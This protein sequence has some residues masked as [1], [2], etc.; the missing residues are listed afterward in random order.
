MAH[1]ILEIVVAIIIAGA[2]F[3]AARYPKV[4]GFLAWEF[5]VSW[6]PAE[7]HSSH[8]L[9]AFKYWACVCT[10]GALIIAL[11]YLAIDRTAFAISEGFFRFLAP[12]VL[13]CGYLQSIGYLILHLYHRRR[14]AQ[15]SVQPDRRDDAAPG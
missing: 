8:Y 1:I 2:L 4:F 5:G 14:E 10:L 11:A 3:L 13:G 12:I 9:R 15:Q 6:I 7:S